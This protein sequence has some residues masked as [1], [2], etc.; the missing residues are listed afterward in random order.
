MESVLPSG[1]EWVRD[2]ASSFDPTNNVV[3]LA[4][5][6][7]LE[8]EWLVIAMGIQLNYDKVFF[9]HC[10]CCSS[11]YK[12]SVVVVVAS[13]AEAC[14][15]A[16][17]FAVFFLLLLQVLLL[18]LSASATEAAVADNF[19]LLSTAV[20]VSP[21]AA[22]FADYFSLL[23]STSPQLLLLYLLDQRPPRRLRHSRR[24]L[25]LSPFL[26]AQDLAGHRGLQ[27]G[28]RALLLPQHPGQVRGGAAE[29]HVPH[30][31]GAQEGAR[32]SVGELREILRKIY[33][34]AVAATRLAS[35]TTLPC[36]SCSG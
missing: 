35:S 17:F 31:K 5:G 13:V 9:L 11:F 2:S 10:S 16:T 26:R 8:Y 15:D 36:L 4:S 29:D 14:V 1:A 32:S 23:P 30:R 6:D 19:V 7:E 20:A 18:L 3:R 22:N 25:Q 34:R 12:H 27:G 33:F 24:W 21:A 28:K